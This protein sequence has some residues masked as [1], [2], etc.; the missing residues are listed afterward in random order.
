MSWVL[1]NVANENV[2]AA[3]LSDHPEIPEIDPR[4]SLY[5]VYEHEVR[6]QDFRKDACNVVSDIVGE[7]PYRQAFD[8]LLTAWANWEGCFITEFG[9]EH[10]FDEALV[11][12]ISDEWFRDHFSSRLPTD[13]AIRLRHDNLDQLIF[14]FS[15]AKIIRPVDMALCGRTIANDP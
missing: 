9:K 2:P 7:T 11:D 5:P 10:H 12:Q 6:R 3:K 8:I 13:S 1:H 14:I 15:L 4:L